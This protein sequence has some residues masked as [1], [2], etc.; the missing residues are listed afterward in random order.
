MSWLRGRPATCRQRI[1]RDG[2]FL[3]SYLRHTPTSADESLAD[4]LNMMTQNLRAYSLGQLREQDLV[5]KI[6]EEQIT[7][8]SKI[9]SIEPVAGQAWTYQD[10]AFG[11]KEV[12]RIRSKSEFTDRIVGKYKV[13]LI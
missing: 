9:R 5:G 3:E 10:Q 11:V 6:R 4:A 8:S 13:R 12:H 2:K 1:S 7:W